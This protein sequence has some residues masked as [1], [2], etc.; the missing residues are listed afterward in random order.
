VFS[1]IPQNYG[2]EQQIHAELDSK[3]ETGASLREIGRKVA[4]EVEKYFEVRVN[5][6][7]IFTKARR[8]EADSNES[9]QE[10]A[11]NTDGKACNTCNKLTPTEIAE[12]VKKELPKAGSEREAAHERGAEIS[13]DGR[14]FTEFC[15]KVTQSAPFP[16]LM[17]PTYHC[18]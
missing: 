1:V 18:R 12:A 16:M 8:M 7:T 10:N 9:P 13:F 17:G 6:T 11:T 5:P 2:I 15:V 3:G 4:A 14:P